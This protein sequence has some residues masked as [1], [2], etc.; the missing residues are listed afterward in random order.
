MEVKV[1]PHKMIENEFD[2]DLS[3]SKVK[4]LIGG[5]G[6][7]K[8][9]IL[10]SIFQFPQEAPSR[11]ISYSSGQNESF[12]RIYKKYQKDNQVYSLEPEEDNTND[13][14]IDSKF[15][16]IY[17]DY[18]FSRLLIFFAIGLN[19][20]GYIIDYFNDTNLSSLK[21]KLD[22]R[23]PKSYT[24]KIN[25]IIDRE[26]LNPG[27]RTIRNTFFHRYLQVFADKYIQTDYD[28]EQSIEKRTVTIETDSIPIEFSNVTRLFAFLSWA[29]N[30]QFIDIDSTEIEI[31]GLELDSYSDGEFQLMAVYSLFDLFDSE[32]T[33][34]LLD[35]IDSH[36]HFNN[37]KI[38][39]DKVRL[40]Q[41]KL[42][43]TTHSADSIIL[44]EFT[45]I[46]LV[47][48]GKIEESTV[49]NQILDRLESLSAGTDY[50]LA[51]AAKVNYLA[52]V[53][54]YFD[55]FIFIELCKKKILDFDLNIM[56]QIHYV[57]CSSGFY[58]S[59]QVFGD[60]KVKWVSS[61]NNCNK[62]SSTKSIF[63]LCDRDNLPT[64]DIQDSGWVISSKNI[65]RQNKIQLKGP[66]NNRYAFL[67][68]WKR[69]EIENYL[70][71]FTMLNNHE[72]LE[73]VNQ[74][75]AQVNQ[76]TEGS[77]CDNQNVQDL[78]VK[79]LLQPLYLKDGYETMPTDESGVDYNKLSAI[80][81]EI[82]VNEIS[83]DIE[84][85]YNFIKG[86][87]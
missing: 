40:I 9:S 36:I 24:D 86:K 28:F 18:K 20:S 62:N 57:K 85:V 46:K 79:S 77:P 60:S 31:D 80:I 68:S 11:I 76:L 82:P 22:F 47:K 61:F 42:I 5:N 59:G 69:R 53:E 50:K 21:L 81:A 32:T 35:E 87:L 63:L 52:L 56:Q 17:F 25:N 13:E 55:W 38:I 49:A 29:V 70:L 83:D 44:N 64:E 75:L 12:S 41:G 71:S 3:D 78:D 4:V 23:I 43:T 26:A 33:L 1:R 10:E 15:K 54:D 2:I 67:M 16:S 39:W 48:E 27:L 65:G 58:N 37:I 73:E 7:G 45:N 51:M 30:N 66:G 6:S 72:K 34:F 19:E 84:N 74:N 8:S 14:V